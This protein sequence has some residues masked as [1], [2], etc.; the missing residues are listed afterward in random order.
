MSEPLPGAPE[1]VLRRFPW[2]FRAMLAICSDLD[3]TPDSRTYFEIARFLNSTEATAMGPGVGLEVGN[4]MYFDMPPGQFSYWGTD[5]RGRAMARALM[6][7]G[8]IDAIHSWGDLATSRGHAERDLAELEGQGCRLEVWI[9]HSRAP[10]NFGPDIMRGSG[11]LPGAAAYHADLTLAY[12]VRHVWRGR[13]TGLTGQDVTVGVGSFLPIL[14]RRQA[15]V[16][17][18]SALKEAVKV[19]LGLG[20]HTRW[21]M[22]GANRVCRPSTLRDGRRVW[23]FLRTNPSWGG[24][25]ESATA[26]GIEEALTARMLS[27][28]VACEGVA[29]LYTH[30]GKVRDRDRPL[31]EGTERAFRHLA[32]LRDEGA[33]QVTSTSRLLRF[34]TVRDSLRYRAVLEGERVVVVIESVDDPVSGPRVPSERDLDGLAFGIAGARP[35]QVRLADGRLLVTEPVRAGDGTT[36][37][38]LPWP[39]LRFPKPGDGF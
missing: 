25:G 35:V 9:D 6:R 12:G 19:A 4:T 10:S 7:S 11:D 13:T 37:A 2:P 3:E 34:V 33:V 5:D 8:H 23:E 22:Y 26:A 32:R 31:G 18:R 28:L 1:V 30:L 39:E 29:V 20:G 17:M 27:R 36:W 16:S 24:P 38:R 14:R 21:R 15:L